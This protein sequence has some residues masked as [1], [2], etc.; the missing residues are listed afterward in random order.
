MDWSLFWV[1]L[2]LYAMYRIGKKKR[3][4]SLQ[5]LEMN[6]RLQANHMVAFLIKIGFTDRQEIAHIKQREEIRRLLKHVG[7][8]R[9]P[10]M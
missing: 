3:E 2:W 6:R 7:N 9:H 5:M 1:I 8:S 4:Q 10:G